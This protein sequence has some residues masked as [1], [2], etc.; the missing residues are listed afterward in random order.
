MIKEIAEE[1][2][3]FADEREWKQFHTPKN[4][5]MA[6]SVEASELL[7]IF[8]WLTPDESARLT[9]KQHARVA[10]EI[11]DVANYL[12]RLCDLLELDLEECAWKKIEINR[13]KYPA[14]IVRG[15]SEKYT[16]YDAR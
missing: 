3:K 2:R 16:D 14:D 13:S 8:Q 10:E 12:I 4:V 7:E 1:L 6:L 9:S 11:G 5:S 15:S